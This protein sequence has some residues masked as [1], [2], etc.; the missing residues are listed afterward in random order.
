MVN[1]SIITICRN[2]ENE[3]ARTIKSILSQE[4]DFNI[5]EL[6]IVD[7]KS[8]DQ[9]MTIIESFRREAESKNLALHINSEADKGIYDAMNKGAD[10]SSG[11]WSIYLNAG[12]CFFNE[13][14][15]SILADACTPDMDII[16]GDSL[17]SYKNRFKIIRSKPENE[18]NYM[19]GMEFCHQSC[20]IRTAYL[21]EHPYTLEFKI[22]GDYDFFTQ[23]YVSGAK[24]RYVR[25]IVS[26]F[27]KSG[28]SSQNGSLVIKENTEIKY[29]YGLISKKEYERIHTS[30][31]KKI[32]IRKFF[33][34]SIIKVR[35][36]IIMA[37]STRNWKTI[38]QIKDQ[39]K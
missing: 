38:D 7:G 34:K 32:K 13:K 6:I 24:F 8:T 33:P 22:G 39:E 27:D 17:Y 4:Y 36:T 1:I 12:D 3:I 28:I 35:H 15:L 30:V 20:A 31:I 19:N 11:K 25:G 26:V 23:A 29:K 9:T 16:Y 21:R 18:I 2:A 14:S 5:I 37:N 10:L